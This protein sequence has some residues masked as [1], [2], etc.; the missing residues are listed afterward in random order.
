MDK[1]G[2]TSIAVIG[3]ACRLPGG[4]D[5]PEQLWEALLRGDD[6]VTEVPPDRWD[7]DEYYDPQPGVPGRSVTKWGGFLDDVAGFDSEF[8]GISE[9]EATAIDPQHRL[10]LET[11]WEAM[12]HAGLTRETMVDSLTGVFVGLTHGDYQLLAADAH[13][14]E[15][16]YGFT[17]SSFSLASG[18]IAYALGVHG[19]ALTVDTACSSGLTAVHLACHSL[20]DGESDLALAG[21]AAVI[22]DPR[23]FVAGSAEGMLSPTGR[24]HAFDVAADGFVSCEGCVVVLLKRLPDALRDGDRILAVIRGTAANQD[25][26]TV[27]I[28]TPSVTAQTAV[29]RAAL[30]AA[31]VDARSIGMVE[32]H[33]PGTPVGDPIEYASLAKV[34]GIEDPC[35]LATVKTNFGHAQSAAGALGLMKTVLALQHG[36]VPQNLHFTRLPDEMA[37]IDTKLFVPQE[38]TP[39]PTN[40]HHPRRAAVSSYGLSGTNAHAILE[41]APEQAPEAAAPEDISAESATTAPL[42]FPLSSTSADELRRTAGRL[43][44][45]VAAH[46]DVALPDLAYTLARRRAHRPVRTAVIASSRPELTKALREVADGDTPYQAAVGQDDRGPVW[47]FSGQGSQWAQMGAELLATE[48]VFAATVAAAE[49]LIAREAGFSVTEAMTASQIV[50]GIDRIQPTLFTMQVALAATMRSYGVRPG[51]VIGHSLGEA[52][53]AV[54]AGALSLEDGV[55][56]ICRRS[57]LM[58]R[59]AGAGAMAS[60]ELPA[61]QVLSELITRGVNDAVVAVVASPQSTVIGGAT[62]TVRDLVA[63][64][65]QRDVMAREIAV[66]VA[67][68]SPQVDPILDELTDVLAELHPMTPEVPFYSATLYDPRERPVCDAGYWVHN[69]RHMV[70]FAPAVQAALEDG[71]RVFAELA[72]HPLLTHAVEQTARSLDMP[73]A[74]L[75]GMRREQALPYGLRGFVADLHSAGA[76]VDFSVL[77]PNGRLV[78]APLPTWTHRRLLLSRGGQESPTHGGCTVSVHPLLGAHVRLQEEPERH[79]WQAE[80]GTAAQPWL[81]DHRIRNVAVLPGAAYCEMALAA[82]RA[83][84]GEAS[85]VRDIR[86]EQALLLDE[87]T[88]VGASAALSSPGVVDFTVETNQ[89]GEQARQATAVLHAADEEQ[90]PAQDMSAL[91]AAHP[92]R[93]DGAEVR[94]RLDQRG[95]QYGPAFTGLAAVHTGEGATGTVLVEVALPGQIRSQQDAYGVHPALLDACFQSVEAHPEV[96]ALGEDVLALPLGIRRLRSYGAARSARYCYT[97]VTKADTSGVEADLDVLDEHGAVLLAVQGLRLGTGASEKRPQRSG[98][99]QAAADHRMAATRIARGGTR[100]RR[101]LAADQ[102]HRHRRCGGHHR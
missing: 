71:Y 100:R 50:T 81:G 32:A 2:V 73:L 90:P 10:L 65:E 72:P 64:W 41:Q 59:I 4:I 77:Y 89:G 101:N 11:S 36:V 3:M 47:V 69:L 39:W 8:F 67:S 26:H 19:P 43:A 80:V 25:G 45:W 13:A 74:A 58:S 63:A 33:G 60:V 66:D 91:L 1:A 46:E 31:G 62:Q 83:V 22:L 97:R 5:S 86:F 76:A 30:A 24:C 42:L 95:V 93:E 23:K 35:A 61:Q 96:Q 40:G 85:E 49:P 48:P 28:A 52:A 75:A 56:V 44:D 99:G 51:A 18:R 12:E 29:Y 55:R 14:V 68:H 70:R 6:L 53:A 79:V 98:A 17:G 7:A 27:N 37:G 34:Y 92:R 54:V 16:P 38:I 57:R 21:G 87:Q 9:R 82:A 15:A 94:K 84:L 88:T 20:I 78:D 102:H